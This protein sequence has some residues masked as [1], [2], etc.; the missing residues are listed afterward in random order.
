M[1]D[2]SGDTG[3]LPFMTAVLIV[4][5]VWL[6][7]L[8][9]NIGF[10][11]DDWWQFSWP[12]WY[13]F[14]QSVWE[15][16]KASQR[17]IEG[18]YTVLSFELF[19]LTRVYYTL[20][21]LLLSAG[22]CL[23]MGACLQR[24]FPG[25]TSLAVLS[26][27]FA[28]VLTP[29]SNLIYM[30]HTDN[31]RVSLLLFWLSVLA[32]QRWAVAPQRLV[33]LAAAV[34]CYWLST[35]TYET[36]AFLIFAVPF[37]VWPIH[38]RGPN[39]MS[40]RSFLTRMSVGI[41]VAFAIFVAARFLVFSGGAVR[42]ASLIPS[43]QL[44]WSYVS[45]LLIYTV[46]P[47][48]RLS[49]DGGSWVWGSIVGLLAAGLLLRS[50]EGDSATGQG[51]T[52]D[53]DTWLYIGALGVATVALG[54]CPYLLAGYSSTIGFTSQS[55]IYSSAT[56]G[57]AILLGL[58]FST[59]QSPKIR[60]I[61]RTVAVCLLMVMAVFLADLRLNWQAAAEKRRKLSASLR[62]QVP[63]AK[64]G[65][66]F[67][68]L[69]LQSYLYR[70][71]TPVA[72]IFQ[73]VDGLVEFVRML[74]GNRD[75]YAYF[76]YLDAKDSDNSEGRRALVSSRGMVARGSLVRPPIPL[77][78]LL[79]LKR[80]H[81]RLVLL[82]GLAARDGVAAIQW[83]AVPSIQSNRQLILPPLPRPPGLKPL[84]LD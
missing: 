48:T 11:G 19:G 26:T 5:C 32:F 62:E 31:S 37:F 8:I 53:G 65:T 77:D 73:G 64:P 28:F 46:A 82:D 61:G 51:R 14:P 12:Y 67:L 72:V 54:M 45:H 35:F 71:G 7:F 80:D 63:N 38:L 44:I 41:C 81:D 59:G 56:F 24:A 49:V 47:L 29:S 66:T 17:P 21:A 36:A 78:T 57:V 13:G 3:L 27:L 52:L 42:H 69:D 9:G 75:L 1:A 70:N 18:L 33:R 76:L 68:L 43:A 15:Y 50:A 30:F 39:V 83:D 2:K 4:L 34:L 22:S 60:L 6:A 84:S 58:V 25:R 23:I 20:T 79:I 40:D 16:A 55:R 10:Q 74:Y